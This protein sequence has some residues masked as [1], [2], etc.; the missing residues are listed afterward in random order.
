MV[1][2]AHSEGRINE[3][4]SPADGSSTFPNGSRVYRL[5]CLNP[6]I[7]MPRSISTISFLFLTLSGGSWEAR[8]DD[9]WIDADPLV[10]ETLMIR[11]GE[12]ERLIQLEKAGLMEIRPVA[13]PR[14]PH[15]AGEN[16]VLGWPVATKVGQTLICAH[17]RIVHHHGDPPR[18]AHSRPAVVL[19]SE[20]NGNTWSDPID[21][22]QFGNTSEPMAITHMICIGAMNGKA[23]VLCKDGLYRSEDEGL[24]WELLH[25]AL[26]QKQTGGGEAQDGD[27]GSGPRMF[28]H[29][30][31]GLVVPVH[32]RNKPVVEMFFSTDEGVTWTR[33]RHHLQGKGVLHPTEPTAMFHDGRLI[34]LSRNQPLPMRGHHRMKEPTPPVM[35]I[36]NTGWFPLEHQALSNISSYRWP[37]TTDIAFNPI[38]RCYEAVVTNRSGGGPGEERD[39]KNQQT[40]NL[41]SISPEHLATGKA[42]QWRFEGTLLRLRSGM[43]KITPDDV[44]AAHPG[45]AVTDVKRGVQHIFIYCGTYRTPTGVY[46]ITRTLDTAKLNAALQ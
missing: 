44:D 17:S 36:S 7:V 9:N 25:G 30:K 20:D 38:T 37:D 31:K 45:G 15:L 5:S 22:R 8:S 23:F 19:R 3:K 42:G 40:V 24:T 41:W 10:A 1:L 12:R 29:P 27:Y 16:H 34:F 26:T 6:S 21:L 32:V 14:G 13:L 18:D 2:N 35:M 43:L 39:E 11:S 33:E 46:R 28:V 4:N